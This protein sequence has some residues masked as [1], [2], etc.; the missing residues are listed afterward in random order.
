MRFFYDTE[1]I[2]DGRTI[3]LVSIGV[4]GDDGREYYAVST[5]FDPDR[6]GSWVRANVLPKL[7]SPSSQVWRTRRRIRDD[8]LEFLTAD[9]GP[10][11]LWAWTGA[12]D[13]VVLCQLWGPMTELPRA[14]PR[15]TRELRQL[16][17]EAG[18]PTLPDRPADAHDALA[19]A[20][21][22]LAKWRSI[23]GT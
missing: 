22:N 23:V 1:F 4:V 16:W 9:S 12:Y 7:P 10:V 20:R 13:H 19:D 6:A 11:E 18:R 3:D 14:I 5:E 8:L 21:H 2:E 17:E 15:Y